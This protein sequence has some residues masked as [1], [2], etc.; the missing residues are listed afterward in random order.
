MTLSTHKKG[1]IL[2]RVFVA[3]AVL[4]F[5]WFGFLMWNLWGF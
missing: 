1:A 4:W 2:A 3:L 5:A